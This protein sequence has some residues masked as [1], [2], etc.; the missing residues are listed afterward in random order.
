[1]V[2]SQHCLADQSSISSLQEGPRCKPVEPDDDPARGQ[3]GWDNQKMKDDD[4]EWSWTGVSRLPYWF[5]ISGYPY[6]QYP[7]QTG[8]NSLYSYATSAV[9]Y[10]LTLTA[11]LD[12]LPVAQTTVIAYCYS[13]RPHRTGQNSSYRSFWTRLVGLPTGYFTLYPNDFN[14]SRALNE[15]P[16]QSYR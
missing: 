5:S 6:P 2:L 16:S 13:E 15:T 3:H 14:K 8:S 7:H 4:Y 12:A 1:M 10:Q 11:R 9:S